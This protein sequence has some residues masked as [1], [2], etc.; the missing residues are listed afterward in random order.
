MLKYAQIDPDLEGYGICAHP[1]KDRKRG[2]T[3]N[4]I[5]STDGIMSVFALNI[6]SNPVSLLWKTPLPC[7]PCYIHSLAMTD[8]FVVFIRNV[9]CPRTKASFFS[10]S[11][12]PLRECTV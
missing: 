5:V 2:L 3:F 11:P 12:D 6:R 4:Y 8:R 9:S 10:L 7:A 1:P